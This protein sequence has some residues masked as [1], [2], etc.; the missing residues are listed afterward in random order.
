LLL[1]LLLT[2]LLSSEL[3]GHVDTIAIPVSGASAFFALNK[4][5]FLN[6]VTFD[7]TIVADKFTDR[8]LFVGVTFHPAICTSEV[9]GVCGA[10]IGNVASATTFA[11][12]NDGTSGEFMPVHM[13]IGTIQPFC[14]ALLGE[15]TLTLALVANKV[16]TLFDL[17]TSVPT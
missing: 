6:Q 5:T 7:V 10:A 8:T 12:L 15:V 1:L 17:V 3:V 2:R 14:S 11:T 9:C 16:G 13:T 4:R